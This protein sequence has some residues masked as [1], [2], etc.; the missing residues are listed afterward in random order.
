MTLNL[1]LKRANRVNVCPGSRFSDYI[2]RNEWVSV[3]D[4]DL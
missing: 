3:F 2:G 1:N 4:W